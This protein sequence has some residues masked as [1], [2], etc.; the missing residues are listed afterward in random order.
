MKFLILLSL[1]SIFLPI[2]SSDFCVVRN[3][4]N[5]NKIDVLC[6]K[7]KTIFGYIDYE[8]NNKDLKYQNDEELKLKIPSEYHYEITDFINKYCYKKKDSLKIKEIINLDKSNDM[9]YLV[10]I[11]I[12]CEFKQ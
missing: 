8:S 11:I 10:K 5:N 9:K 2:N 1:F 3:I 4:L 7:K 6:D 12:S